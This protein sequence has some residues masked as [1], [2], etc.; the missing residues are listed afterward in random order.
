MN[1]KLSFLDRYLT[2]W[3][4][5]A[6]FV[7]VG[8]GYFFPETESFINRFNSGSTNIPI[9]IGLIVMMY[10]PLAKVRYEHL[11]KVFSNIK[12]IALSLLMNWIIGPVLMFLLAIIFLH[13]KPE[14]MGGLI[15]I[16]IAR[17]IA[18]VLV[19]NDLARGDKEY[20]AG[21]VAL[22]SI[23]Q[24][25]FYSVLAWLFITVLPPYFGVDGADIEVSMSEVAKSVFIYLG[26][27][28]IAGFLTRL[29]CI[30]AKGE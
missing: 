14:Y 19:W 28:F 7:G 30:R 16:G 3:I 6:M 11:G 2:L 5:A 10:P 9:A 27:P 8:I 20:A 29:A 21:L 25:L 12:V 13:D 22:N 15:L 23:F 26:V 4:F 17:C 1:K 24:V 18:M